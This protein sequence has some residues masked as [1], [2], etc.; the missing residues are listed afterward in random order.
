LKVYEFL[1]IFNVLTEQ[2]KQL[3]IIINFKTP[4]FEASFDDEYELS[5]FKISKI[6]EYYGAV[7]IEGKD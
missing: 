7:V 2:Q 5:K 1:D 6:L 3:E 4:N